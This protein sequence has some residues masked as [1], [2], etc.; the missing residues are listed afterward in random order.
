MNLR[1]EPLRAYSTDDQGE[2]LIEDDAEEVMS[3][4]SDMEELHRQNLALLGVTPPEPSARAHADAHGDDLVTVPAAEWDR[5]REQAAHS[6]EALY[7]AARPFLGLPPPVSAMTDADA[8]EE[9]YRAYSE[10]TLKAT[11]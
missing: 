6:P 10:Q 9:A 3:E 2:Y 5:L 1:I 8:D 7:E 11:L 4:P